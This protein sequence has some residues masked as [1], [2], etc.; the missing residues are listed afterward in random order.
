VFGGLH[1]EHMKWAVPR[2][3]PFV[4]LLKAT[5]RWIWNTGAMADR[6]KP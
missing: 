4:L 6:G 1:E 2:L 5:R 3:R